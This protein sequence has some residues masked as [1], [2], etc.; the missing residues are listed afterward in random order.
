MD[1]NLVEFFRADRATAFRRAISEFC[2]YYHLRQPRIEWYEYIDWGKTAGRTFEDGR[3]HLVHP[4]N[5]K[6]GRIYKSERMWVQTVYHELAHYLFW[7]DA[8]RKAE[9]FT[10]RMVRGLRRTTRRSSAQPARRIIAGK[11]VASGRRSAAAL[12]ARGAFR[13]RTVTRRAPV[14]TKRGTRK[15]LLPARRSVRTAKL[16][17]AR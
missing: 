7:T 13:V 16:A 12:A 6:R 9:A 5:W 4:E 15:D 14:T 10:Y 11:R 3:I 1:R 17:N 8:E 2:R